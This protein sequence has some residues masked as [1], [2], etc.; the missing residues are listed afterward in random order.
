MESNKPETASI[1][2]LMDDAKKAIHLGA[3]RGFARYTSEKSVSC[4]DGIGDGM[5]PREY[6]NFVDDNI[7]I[8]TEAVEDADDC[9]ISPSPVDKYVGVMYE[10]GIT[11]L[12][13]RYADAITANEIEIIDLTEKL[14]NARKRQR[15]LIEL[16]DRVWG[17]MHLT[18]K[19]IRAA[20]DEFMDMD[21]DALDDWMETTR[22]VLRQNGFERDGTPLGESTYSVDTDAIVEKRKERLMK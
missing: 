16:S 19:D 11:W 7:A 18:A 13:T 6:T 8:M 17:V 5:Y 20:A 15:D 3:I 9:A 2:D 10:R 12:G 1:D 4:I 22:S 21:V 14:S